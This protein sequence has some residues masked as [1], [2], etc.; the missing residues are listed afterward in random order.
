MKG[1]V[2][3]FLEKNKLPAFFKRRVR[4][5]RNGGEKNEQRKDNALMN[6]THDAFCKMKLGGQLMGYV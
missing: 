5:A 2:R 3:L 4:D 6:T 1:Y